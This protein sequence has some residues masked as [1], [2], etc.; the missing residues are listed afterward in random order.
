MAEILNRWG[1]QFQTVHETGQLLSSKVQE[2]ERSAQISVHTAEKNGR[3]LQLAL[4]QQQGRLDLREN[5]LNNQQWKRSMQ[6][7]R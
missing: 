2:L 3:N 6:I 7:S 4:M 1:Q 5:R